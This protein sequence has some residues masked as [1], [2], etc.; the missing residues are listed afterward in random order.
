M[1]KPNVLAVVGGKEITQNDVEEI[2]ASLGPQAAAQYRNPEGQARLLDEAINR[3]LLYL[4]AVDNQLDKEKEFQEQLAN[5]KENILR[6]YAVSRL[7]DP[8]KVTD[9]E[10]EDYYST[11]KD[12][13]LNPISIKASHILLKDEDKSN[14]VYSQIEA[15]TSFEDAAK[16]SSCEGVDL[17]YFSRGKMVQEFEDVAFKMAV[18]EVSKPVKT[19]FG[20][21]II[22]IYDRRIGKSRTF[23]E[24]QEDL[25]N[26]LQSEK[27]NDLY[28]G[29]VKSLRG[30]YGVTMK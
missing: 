26:F 24:V 25:K 9:K 13:F 12:H 30:K 8:V 18:D 6:D 28:F 3:R 11:H 20:Y 16:A 5:V 21:H 1:N 17:G 10:A 15:G 23:E 7:L 22:K 4:D 19:E 2:L 27:R 14:E 29:K